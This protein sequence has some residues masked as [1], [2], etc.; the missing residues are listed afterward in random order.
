MIQ[1][2][3]TKCTVQPW[4]RTPSSSARWC[5]PRPGKDGSS[6]GGYS[7][8]G[9][10]NDADE[11]FVRMRMKPARTTRSGEKPSMPG[12]GDIE[13]FATASLCGR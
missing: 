12:Q 6:E 3:V 13:G 8:G 10:R 11:T 7:A 4:M 2:G 1:L 9:L 5:V